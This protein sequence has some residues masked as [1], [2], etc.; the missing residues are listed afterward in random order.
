MQYGGIIIMEGGVKWVRSFVLLNFVYYF[1]KL[2]LIF[3]DLHLE[4]PIKLNFSGE[5]L[6]DAGILEFLI[7]S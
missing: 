5:G 7:F 2:I 4:N 6:E 1:T 3:E